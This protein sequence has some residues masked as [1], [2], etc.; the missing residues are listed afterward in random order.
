MLVLWFKFFEFLVLLLKLDI[1]EYTLPFVQT[2]FP[3]HG[4]TRFRLALP[5]AF[6]NIFEIKV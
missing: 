5:V 6:E 3:T 1:H 4:G 2:F